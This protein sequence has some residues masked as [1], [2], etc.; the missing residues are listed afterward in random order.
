MFCLAFFAQVSIQQIQLA[1][2]LNERFICRRKCWGRETG[3]NEQIDFSNIRV[4]MPGTAWPIFNFLRRLV[5]RLVRLS[6]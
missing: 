3:R 6:D 2:F 5:G 4:H 1:T